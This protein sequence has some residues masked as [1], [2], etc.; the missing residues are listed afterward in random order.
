MAVFGLVGLFTQY[1][2]VPFL[3]SSLHVPDAAIGLMA[4]TGAA[5]DSLMAAFARADWILYLG[6]LVGF[7]SACG[8]II[9]RS[10]MTK[11]V[12]PF[13]VGAVFS[14]VASFQVFC[15]ILCFYCF[16]VY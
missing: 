11:C 10:L 8:T 14:V 16:Y 12:G 13:E 1:V 3:T 2:A 4:V 5:V 7:L 9:C 6:G 15:S